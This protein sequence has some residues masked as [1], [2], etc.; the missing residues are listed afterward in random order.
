MLEVFGNRSFHK[1][2]EQHAGSGV[3]KL[4]HGFV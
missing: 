2:C 3:T 4:M 1:S